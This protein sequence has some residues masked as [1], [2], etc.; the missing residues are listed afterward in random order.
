L[1]F[2]FQSWQLHIKSWTHDIAQIAGE[3]C[4]HPIDGTVDSLSSSNF[5]AA[6]VAAMGI[7]DWAT[8]LFATSIAALAI[9]G[10]LK[11]RFAPS[12]VS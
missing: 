8:L 9:V 5:M 4:V 10:E 3:A 6:N 1:I 7:L 12:L 11:V 2:L